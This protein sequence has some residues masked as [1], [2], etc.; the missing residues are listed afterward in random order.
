[1][2][3][4][5]DSKAVPALD[6]DGQTLRLSRRVEGGVA[7]VCWAVR[8]GRWQRWASPAY[9]RS[10]DLQEVW[11]RSQQFVGNEAGQLLLAGGV[12]EWQIYFY[13]GNSWSNAQ[14]SGDLRSNSGLPNADVAVPP[15]GAVVISPPPPPSAALPL[16]LQLPAAVR[17]VITLD[18]KTLTR[19]VALGPSGV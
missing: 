15:L 17:L 8:N 6:F 5:H 1:M 19:D 13:R 14:S 3:G 16:T 7:L 11:M 4:L 12:G 18:G 2:Q 9:T 10:N